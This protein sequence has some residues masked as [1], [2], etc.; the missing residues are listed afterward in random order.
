MQIRA[1]WYII[2]SVVNALAV[3][4]VTETGAP[5]RER[6]LKSSLRY[7]GE[8]HPSA[9]SGN[10]VSLCGQPRYRLLS[11]KPEWNRGLTASVAQGDEGGYFFEENS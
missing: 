7:D 9:H 3:G 4:E 10:R 6:Q 1:F 5:E 8:M 11:Y 2:L